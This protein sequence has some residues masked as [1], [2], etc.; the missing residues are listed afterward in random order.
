MSLSE[1][2]SR[3]TSRSIWAKGV[4][5][6]ELGIIVA[7]TAIY[8]SAAL[9]LLSLDLTYFKPLH[10]YIF[11]YG[12][13]VVC[14][15]TSGRARYVLSEH[16][17]PIQLWA[18]MLAVVSM[19]FLLMPIGDTGIEVL[20]DR[21]HFGLML[22]STLLLLGASDRVEFAI[23]LL[24]CVVVASCG[25]NLAEFFLGGT[26]IEWM[27]TVPGR[28]AGLFRDSNDSA[29]FIALAVPIIALNSSSRMRWSLYAITFAGIYVTFSRGGFVSWLAFVAITEVLRGYGG[30][31]WG[32][33]VFLTVT[34]SIL[35][36]ASAVY[37][38]S[39]LTELARQALSPY[40]TTNTT[41]RIEFLNNA[42]TQER[43]YVLE[44]GLEVF[45]ESP[46]LGKGVGYT[47][48]WTERVSVHNVFVLFLAEL[49][50]IGGVW[51]FFWVAAL[52]CYGPPYGFLIAFM[53][54]VTSF[55]NHTSCERPAVAM[56]IAL[57]LFAAARQRNL[58]AY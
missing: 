30:Q 23:G 13:A 46:I 54:V 53:F 17:M 57:Y 16:W 50:L 11:V 10:F 39:D 8:S 2:P 7:F 56:L 42:S 18:L 52:W 36:A 44:R 34:G 9:Y 55:L 14:F 20:I 40:L 22:V 47:H 48:A 37:F 6:P 29:M 35:V 31:V 5:I 4:G 43:M 3:Q 21:V 41:A 25:V 38:S 1:Q 26:Y 28:A 24:K 51:M 27:T 49:G 15:L 19:Q 33:R 58:Q 45:A 32:R 12:S